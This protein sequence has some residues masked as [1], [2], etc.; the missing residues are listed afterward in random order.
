MRVGTLDIWDAIE[1]ALAMR[2]LWG[3]R[4]R[5]IVPHNEVLPIA[6]LHKG[7]QFVEFTLVAAPGGRHDPW[8][9]FDPDRR[10][11]KL[12]WDKPPSLGEI[13]DLVQEKVEEVQS[14]YRGCE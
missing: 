5:G 3:T 11:L 13:D 4:V 12:W 14:A 2:S 10:P 7:Y 1:G 6:A 9:L 8:A